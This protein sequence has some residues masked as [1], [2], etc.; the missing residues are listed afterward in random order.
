MFWRISS[1]QIIPSLYGL[2]SRSKTYWVFQLQT[3]PLQ[4]D[5]SSSPWDKSR[6]KILPRASQ[7]DAPLSAQKLDWLHYLNR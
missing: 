1:S 7:R 4:K 5:I 6:Q 3:E 2:Q